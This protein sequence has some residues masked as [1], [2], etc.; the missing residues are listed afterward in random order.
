M[1]VLYYLTILREPIREAHGHVF[2]AVIGLR[3]AA[4]VV[5]NDNANNGLIGTGVAAHR[6]VSRVSYSVKLISVLKPELY[7]KRAGYLQIYLTGQ[8]TPMVEIRWTKAIV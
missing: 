7:Y 6:G 2:Q 5:T 3:S 8:H 4:S 1:S